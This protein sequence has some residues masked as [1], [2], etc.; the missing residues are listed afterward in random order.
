[1][2]LSQSL[3]EKGPPGLPVRLT[4]DKRTGKVHHEQLSHVLTV[5]EKEAD[6]LG[7]AGETVTAMETIPCVVTSIDRPQTE[8]VSLG[9]VNIFI[10]VRNH[11]AF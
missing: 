3:Q 2:F 8:N 9:L 4:H 1:M 7:C 11:R 5:R 6:F 10:R